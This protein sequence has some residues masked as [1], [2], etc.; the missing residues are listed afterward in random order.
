MFDLNY[1]GQGGDK[2]LVKAVKVRKGGWIAK[3]Q[4]VLLIKD[5]QDKI[6]KIKAEGP[7]KVEKIHIAVGDKVDK[8]YGFQNVYLVQFLDVFLFLSHYHFPYFLLQ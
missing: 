8:G 6:H 4:V 5:A 1:V 2:A 7:G 3:G